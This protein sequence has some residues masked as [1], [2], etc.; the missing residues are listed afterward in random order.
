M[1]FNDGE[2]LTSCIYASVL[3]R[4]PCYI[5]HP[6]DISSSNFPF[7]TRDTSIVYVYIGVGQSK[8]AS[9][10]SSDHLR[11]AYI[12]LQFSGVKISF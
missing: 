10:S 4:Q 7:P 8:C 3:I 9:V 5:P 1:L 6:T 11:H 2:T 12:D